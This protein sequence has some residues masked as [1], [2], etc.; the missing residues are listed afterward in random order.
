MKANSTTLKAGAAT[1]AALSVAP[2]VAD[3]DV[4]YVTDRPVTVDFSV[5]GG[6]LGTTGVGWDIDGINGDD[7]QF[8][9]RRIGYNTYYT[10]ITNNG[11]TKVQ[12]VRG[13][14]DFPGLYGLGPVLFAREWGRSQLIVAS[15]SSTFGPQITA[16]YT[17]YPP[18]FNGIWTHAK[19]VTPPSGTP[20]T[21]SQRASF[22]Q[23]QYGA[24]SDR[25]LMPFGFDFAGQQHVG[26]AR[27]RFD[28]EPHARLVIERW[29]Y[30]SEPETAV[31]VNNIPV[32]PAVVPALTLLAMGAAG[33]RQWRKRQA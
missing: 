6:G 29:A 15:E 27:I 5:L 33:L 7:T 32:P 2:A 24:D 31:H 25:F 21:V 10:N 20:Q 26:W 18:P 28:Y 14:L 19:L 30:E 17:W 8:G 9:V 11:S 4:V 22:S 16:P 3:A 13:S 1:A 23:G 12:D